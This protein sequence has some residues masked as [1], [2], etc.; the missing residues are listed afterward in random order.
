MVDKLLLQ[1]GQDIYFPEGDFYLHQPTIADIAVFGENRYYLMIKILSSPLE[2]LLQKDKTDLEGVD[3]FDVIMSMIQQ[4]DSFNLSFK[5]FLIMMISGVSSVEY[6]P[7]R[8]ICLIKEELDNGTFK[9]T[10]AIIDKN[11]LEQLIPYIEEILNAD[12]TVQKSEFDPANK[13]AKEIMEKILRG[14]ERAHGKDKKKSSVSLLTYYCTLLGVNGFTQ[15]Q[16]NKMTIVQL[17][18]VAEMYKRKVIYDEYFS[19]GLVAGHKDEDEPM[20]HWLD[21]NLDDDSDKRPEQPQSLY[22]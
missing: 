7:D 18:S 12:A 19:V 17:C 1:T 6:F 8:I 22:I 11:L 4:Q 20:K 3:K 15:E 10:T 5:M 14:R 2:D 9:T 13:R 16:I 21:P